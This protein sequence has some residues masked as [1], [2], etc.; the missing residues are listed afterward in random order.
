MSLV[1]VTLSLSLRVACSWVA[2]GLGGGGGECVGG[3]GW[4]VCEGVTVEL[5][6]VNCWE[7]STPSFV[8]SKLSL[9]V[10]AVVAST[11]DILQ[12]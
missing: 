4:D 8:M 3:G 12:P 2:T 1:T 9:V 6:D 5:A 7:D 11:A 10:A